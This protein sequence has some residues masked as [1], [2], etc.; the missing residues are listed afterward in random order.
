M[1]GAKKQEPSAYANNAEVLIIYP[2]CCRPIIGR[3][4]E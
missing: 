1:I 2:V 3:T 4:V